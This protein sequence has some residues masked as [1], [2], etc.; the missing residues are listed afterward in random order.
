MPSWQSYVVH[1]LLRFMV[2]RRLAKVFTPLQARAVFNAS[3]LAKVRGVEFTPDTRG[4]VAGEWAHASQK[5][6]TDA[7]ML[8]LHGG[9]YFACSPKL[10]R[11][12]TGAFA[13]RGLRVFAPSYR[14]APEHPFPAAIE[15][16]LAVYKNLLAQSH[17]AQIIIAGD[18]AGGGLAMGMLLA[19]RESGLPLPAGV[20]LFSPWTDLAVTGA[21]IQTNA[22]RE[23]L[24][25]GARIKEA[26]ALYLADTPPETPS[27]SPLYGD[28]SQ[29]P[30]VLIQASDREILLDDSVRLAERLKAAGGVVELQIWPNMPHVWQFGQSFLPEARAALSKAVDFAYK[31]LASTAPTA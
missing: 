19:A 17:P 13:L 29:F 7:I 24:L 14:L 2:Q 1:P 4:G 5:S 18:S 3:P 12:L 30:P 26:A 27:A 28:L 10:Y 15:D 6:K 11:P 9:G 31:T 22:K 20:I 23:S 25:V 21:S 16:A 8:Y